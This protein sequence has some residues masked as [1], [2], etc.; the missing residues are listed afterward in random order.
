MKRQYKFICWIL[1]SLMGIW[2][3][4]TVLQGP[5]ALKR[6]IPGRVVRFVLGSPGAVQDVDDLADELSMPST[7]AALRLW[8]ESV[9]DA[10]RTKN[11]PADAVNNSWPIACASRPDIA[12]APVLAQ[13]RAVLWC[14]PE[15]CLHVD[16][17]GRVTAVVL[18]WAHLRVGLVVRP[19]GNAPPLNGTFYERQP[20]PDIRV[21]SITS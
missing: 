1:L 9:L 13:H 19:G 3:V 2:V 12:P 11:I 16:A 14:T 18:S 4:Y 10:Q 7:A 5:F 21:F 20:S 17:Q 6:S 8:A 15:T